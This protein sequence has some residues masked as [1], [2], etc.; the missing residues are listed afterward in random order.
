M[1]TKFMNVHEQFMNSSLTVH[2]RFARVNSC[3]TTAHDCIWG[4]IN[5]TLEVYGL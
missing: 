4:E 3:C 2:E 5:K 1:N